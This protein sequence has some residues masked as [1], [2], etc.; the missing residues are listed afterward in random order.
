MECGIWDCGLSVDGMGL[1]IDGAGGGEGRGRDGGGLGSL[2]SFEAAF[3][4]WGRAGGEG[5]GGV[6]MDGILT[7]HEFWSYVVS[8]NRLAQ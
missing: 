8:I 1:E 2:E 5:E 6:W 4:A 3:A 7:V